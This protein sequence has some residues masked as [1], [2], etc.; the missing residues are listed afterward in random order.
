MAAFQFPDGMQ[1]LQ[2]IAHDPSQTKAQAA[3]K[4]GNWHW[5]DNPTKAAA[6]DALLWDTA[7]FITINNLLTSSVFQIPTFTTGTLPA[8]GNKGRLVFTTDDNTFRVDNGSTWVAIGGGGGGVTAS[9]TLTLNQL[10][11]GDGSSV[12]KTL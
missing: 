7:G 6:A 1:I 4:T 8:A 5:V 9:S 10:I 2:G 12:V 3:D 11:L